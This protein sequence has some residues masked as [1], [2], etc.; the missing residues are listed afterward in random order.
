MTASAEGRAPDE[1]I[2]MTVSERSA[3]EWPGEVVTG[4]LAARLREAEQAAGRA[5]RTRSPG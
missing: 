2:K 5:G 4:W 1:R 3:S